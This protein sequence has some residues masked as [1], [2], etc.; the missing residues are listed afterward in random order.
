M[1]GADDVDTEAWEDIDVTVGEIAELIT[2][3]GAIVAAFGSVASILQGRRN[4]EKIQEVHLSIN[5]RMDQLLESSKLAAHAAGVSE[6]KLRISPTG[7]DTII[8]PEQ[9]LKVN[10]EQK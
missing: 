6:E 2:S 3:I 10:T 1:V 8:V 7:P 5:S 4:S 9:I